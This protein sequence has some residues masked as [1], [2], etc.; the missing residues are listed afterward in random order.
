VFLN[1]G[2]LADPVEA[3]DPLHKEQMEFKAKMSKKGTPEFCFGTAGNVENKPEA[4]S[5]TRNL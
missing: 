4:L 2:H 5:L 1:V 3:I